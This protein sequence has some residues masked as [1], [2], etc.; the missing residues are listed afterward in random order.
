MT[1]KTRGRMSAHERAI[2]EKLADA[3]ELRRLLTH[4]LEIAK[5]A[6]DAADIS[7]NLLEALL[8]VKEEGD[9]NG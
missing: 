4:D 7:V 6:A 2:R 9:T 3:L 5:V 8:A 1:G